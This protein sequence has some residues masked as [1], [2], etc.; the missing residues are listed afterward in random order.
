MRHRGLVF[1]MMAFMLALAGCKD[2][3]DISVT[4][5]EL[6]SISPRGFKSVD[7]YLSAEV[8]NP[9]KQ[10]KLTEIEGVVVHSGKVIGKL[11]MDPV[12]LAAK[13]SEKYNL[14]A[15]ASLAEGAGFKDF[16]VLASPT[17][18][19]GC[20]IDISA[21]AAYG[22]GAPMAVKMKNISLKELLN[23]I[24]NEKN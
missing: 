19:D 6:E 14:K 16:M 2:L 18:L 21:K 7:L 15:N 4:S 11:A 22:K 24:G 10:I 23:S 12:V 17:G 13:S 20:T 5:V 1:L 3:K 8:Y 9:A